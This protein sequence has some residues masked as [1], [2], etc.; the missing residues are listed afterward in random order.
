MN[1]ELLQEIFREVNVLGIP[2]AE[3]EF[4]TD[5]GLGFNEALEKVEQI[6]IN[7]MENSRGYGVKDL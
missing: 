4:L 3:G 1:D 5:K 7:K 6:I 2:C